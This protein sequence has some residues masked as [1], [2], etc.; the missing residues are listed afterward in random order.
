[1]IVSI[2]HSSSPPPVLRYISNTPRPVNTNTPVLFNPPPGTVNGANKLDI[3]DVGAGGLGLVIEG[4]GL[5]AGVGNATV[6]EGTIG[7]TGCVSS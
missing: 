1:M 4:I 2:A 3:P 5:V 7:E 6:G